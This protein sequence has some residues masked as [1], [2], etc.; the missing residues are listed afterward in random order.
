MADDV[1]F[2]LPELDGR[3][4]R[5]K[6][7]K[8]KGLQKQEVSHEAA[9]EYNSYGVPVGKGRN[10]LRSYIG[11]IVRETISILLDDWRRVPLEMK[12]TLW[13]HFQK[14]FKLSLKCKSQVLKWMGVASRNFRC[15][16][17][18]EFVLPNKDDR[19]SLRLPPIEYPSIKKEDW[20]LF[21]DKVLS[22]Q[23][24]EKSKKAK[25]K[26]AK[27]VYNH[28]LGSTGYGGMLYRKVSVVIWSNYSNISNLMR[29]I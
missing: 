6:Q 9:I 7:T 23:F 21:V 10:D 8:K 15:E 13:V 20:K 11:V 14:K 22:E 24:Q 1:E 5:R 25:D 4:R 28:R 12:E 19:K 26:R 17:A 27:N 18:T 16:L 2:T 29:I 3:P